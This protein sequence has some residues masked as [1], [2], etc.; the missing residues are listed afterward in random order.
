MELVSL[1]IDPE[2]LKERQKA[3]EAPC[4]IEPPKFPYGTC[5]YLDD[6]T[7]EALG[8]KEMPA[9]GT[10]LKVTG[11]AKVTGT[12]ER[13]FETGKGTEKRRTLDIQITDMA[14]E[15]GKKSATF[16]DSADKLY[17]KK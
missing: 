11:M 14:L 2:A 6:A 12:S 5:L 1:A 7:L 17:G 4:E 8:V 13:E 3:M 10:L 16:K 15:G 9:T